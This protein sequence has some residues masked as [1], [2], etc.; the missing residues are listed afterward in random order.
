L[1]EQAGLRLEPSSPLPT[2]PS[3]TS[4]PL[5]STTRF[6]SPQTFPALVHCN[7][8]AFLRSTSCPTPH[9]SH[10]V[11]SRSLRFAL[12]PP[13]SYPALLLSYY[14]TTAPRPSLRAQS[15]P[16]ALLPHPA[17]LRP[18]CA[19]GRRQGLRQP[20]KDLGHCPG[21]RRAQGRQGLGGQAPRHPVLGHSSGS[22]TVR[23]SNVGSTAL[24]FS[25]RSGGGRVV[26]LLGRHALPHRL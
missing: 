4:S 5:S 12:V 2:S 3:T 20:P 19:G 11:R 9:H 1:L 26:V 7:N 21:D 8:M 17:P 23:S 16:T 18:P 22:T 14:R 24:A 13:P 15:S 10:V 6:A 25:P